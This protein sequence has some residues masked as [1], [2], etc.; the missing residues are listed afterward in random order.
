MIDPAYGD[1]LARG[2]AHQQAGLAVDAMLCYR[3]ALKVNRN[4][5]QAHFHLGEVLRDL[6]LRND[7]IA[8]WRGALTW[9][10]RH[11]PSL[12]A[13]ADELRRAGAVADAATYYRQAVASEPAH[14]GARTALALTLGGTGDAAAL[15][16]L[17]AQIDTQG[18]FDDWD[19]LGRMLAMAPRSASRHALLQRVAALHAADLP[20]L[21]LGL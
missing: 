12:L 2:Q 6:G 7:A 8:A 17:R 10:P 20:P 11:V 3:Q 13:L 15:D 21:L 18:G 19:A 4:A 5:V 14:G 16:E 9:Q 1:W